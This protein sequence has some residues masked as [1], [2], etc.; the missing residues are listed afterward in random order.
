MR[1][2]STDQ[3]V[4]AVHRCACHEWHPV[5]AI[6]DWMVRRG[7]DDLILARVLAETSGIWR[8]GH[9][10]LTHEDLADRIRAAGGIGCGYALQA[11][12]L[13]SGETELV[14]GLYR[15]VVTTELGISMVPVKMV[16][17]NESPFA[18]PWP[19]TTAAEQ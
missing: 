7:G 16:I 12:K 5:A 18:W 4:P 8:P 10:E 14:N 3:L 2:M 11:T 15:W 13:L 19:T 1:P 9:C 6:G 17:E